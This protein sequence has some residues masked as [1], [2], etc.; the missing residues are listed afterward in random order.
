VKLRFE[1]SRLLPG[2]AGSV[3]GRLHLFQHV[4][5]LERATCGELWAEESTRGEA[6]RLLGKGDPVREI[7][8]PVD[9]FAAR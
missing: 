2:P 9:D 4:P 6:D 8:T 3:G 5:A 7:E 1:D